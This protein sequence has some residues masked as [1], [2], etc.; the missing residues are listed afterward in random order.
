MTYTEKILTIIA[1]ILFMDWIDTSPWVHIAKV[2][3]GKYKR[4]FINW[5]NGTK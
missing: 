3:Y 2:K 1:I 5:Y 4:K